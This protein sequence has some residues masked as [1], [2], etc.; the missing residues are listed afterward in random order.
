MHETLPSRVVFGSGSVDQLPTE[1]TRLQ[2]ERVLVLSTPE[3][4]QQA[5]EVTRSSEIVSRVSSMKR[6][7]TFRSKQLM[8]RLP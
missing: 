1:V 8:P 2:A 4:R 5:E 3:Q 6:S 7:C